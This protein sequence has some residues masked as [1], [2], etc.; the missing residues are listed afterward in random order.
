MRQRPAG[1]SLRAPETLLNQFANF[2]IIFY[3]LL[4][5][6]DGAKGFLG[7]TQKAS[8]KWDCKGLQKCFRVCFGD[9]RSV[10]GVSMRL[11]RLQRHFNT[12]IKGFRD[13]SR[14]VKGN[15]GI[16]EAFKG[17]IKRFLGRLK[18]FQ[19]QS[20]GRGRFKD[21]QG[22]FDVFQIR[23]V[24]CKTSGTSKRYQENFKYEDLNKNS[25]GLWMFQR[26]SKEFQERFKWL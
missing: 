24:P 9:F 6:L 8:K 21:I 17:V 22:H 19:W 25:I 4:G 23:V 12:S 10:L 14:D 3:L 16:L 1:A 26:F 15:L 7:C 11:R 13:V 5:V 20:F 18:A 2:Q